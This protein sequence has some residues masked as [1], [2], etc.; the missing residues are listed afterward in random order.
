MKI[1][2]FINEI[3]FESKMLKQRV[4]KERKRSKL[5]SRKR[6]RKGFPKMNRLSGDRKVKE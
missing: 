5:Q 4:Y 3:R 6:L 2:H 1:E